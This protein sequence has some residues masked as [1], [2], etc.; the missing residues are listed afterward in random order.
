MKLIA[1]LVLI[2][3]FGILLF[4]GS[5]GNPTPTTIHGNAMGTTWSLKCHNPEKYRPLIKQ[6]ILHYENLLSHWKPNSELSQLNAGKIQTPSPELQKILTLANKFKVE[7]NGA[8]D[9]TL[10]RQTQTAGFAPPLPTTAHSYDLSA[11]AKGYTIDGLTEILRAAGLKNFIIELGGE[12]YASGTQPDGT[13]WTIQ[14]PSPTGKEPT[15]INLTNQAIATSGNYQQI[16]NIKD[17]KITSHLINPITGKPKKAPPT[18]ISIIAKD[19]TTADSY[20][21][22]LFINPELSLPKQ[23]KML[24]FTINAPQ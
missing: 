21:T 22:A 5:K 11:M 2:V 9:H 19:G 14:I 7:T 15:T 17:G 16:A 24:P 12:C 4:K 6:K 3:T 10:L 18:S 20:A 1:A 13:P 8:F 23:I